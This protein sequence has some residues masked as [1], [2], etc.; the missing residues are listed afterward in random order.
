MRQ[1][2]DEGLIHAD[3]ELWGDV[4]LEHLVGHAQVHVL[5]ES[6]VIG[7]QLLSLTCCSP[8]VMADDQIALLFRNICACVMRVKLCDSSE[9]VRTAND[10][11]EVQHSQTSA[12][13]HWLSLAHKTWRQMGSNC[14]QVWVQNE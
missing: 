11:S 14:W 2:V 8:A 13:W 4:A 10:K 3:H 9:A 5:D 7:W 6:W 12:T 1:E